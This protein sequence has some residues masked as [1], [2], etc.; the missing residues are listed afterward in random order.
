MVTFTINLEVM[1]RVG[2]PQNETFRGWLETQRRDK[3]L[4]KISGSNTNPLI[5]R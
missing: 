5:K 2:T 4:V 3:A 1:S